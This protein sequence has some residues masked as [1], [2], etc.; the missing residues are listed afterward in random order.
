VAIRWVQHSFRTTLHALRT[1]LIPQLAR[2]LGYLRDNRQT[3]TE[4]PQGG[5]VLGARVAIFCHFDRG[6][7]VREH[8]L[9]YIRSLNAA[10][11][12]I[13]LVSNSGRLKPAALEEIR[14]LCAA[15]LVRRN[16]G[17]DFGAWRDA[18]ERLDLPRTNTEILLLVNDSVYGPLQS[19]ESTLSQIDF[20]LADVWGLTE[21]W[22]SRYHLQSFFLAIAPRVM[23]SPAWRQFWM[24]VRPVPSKLWVIDR[25]EVGLSQVLLQAGF[26]CRAVWPYSH[27]VTQVDPSLLVKQLDKRETISTDQLIDFRRAHANRIRAAAAARIPL[28]PTSDLWRQLLKAGFPFLKRELLRDNPSGVLDIS[29]WRLVLDELQLDASAIDADLQRALRNRSP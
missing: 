23:G 2:P 8:V 15:V 24:N 12:S 13:A 29:D 14:S 27:L 10:G 1:R 26:R 11:F 28:N 20:S 5:T 21:S 9:Q 3:V 16:V 18:L 6:G 17:Y 22:Q 19:I 7:I 4:W 25:Y